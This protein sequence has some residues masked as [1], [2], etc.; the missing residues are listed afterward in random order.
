MIPC[1][2]VGPVIPC[3][4]VAPVVPCGPVG[5]VVPDPAL[6]AYDAVVAKDADIALSIEPLTASA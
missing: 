4:P 1:G 5:P 2:P 3:I 6:S